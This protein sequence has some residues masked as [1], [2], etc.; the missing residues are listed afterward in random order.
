MSGESEFKSKP[1]A[2]LHVCDPTMGSR[3]QGVPGA[4]GLSA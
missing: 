1:D 3:E 2:E 4:H